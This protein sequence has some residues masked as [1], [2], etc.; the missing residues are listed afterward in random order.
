MTHELGHNFG[1]RH[2]DSASNL[3]MGPAVSRKEPIW[4]SNSIGTMNTE[5]TYDACLDG[6]TDRSGQ[7]LFR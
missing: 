5:L 3:V 7:V 6:F 2:D 4:S 1:L